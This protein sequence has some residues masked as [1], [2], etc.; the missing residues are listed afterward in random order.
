MENEAQLWEKKLKEL[1][2]NVED[3]IKYVTAWWLRVSVIIEVK[4]K[5]SESVMEHITQLM[6]YLRQVLREQLDQWFVPG[7]LFT[8]TQLAAWVVDRSG[9]LGTQTSFNIHKEPKKFIQVILACSMLLP[10]RLG[11]DITMRI[12]REP[13]NNGLSQ[14]LHS[15]SKEITIDDYA[16]NAHTQQWMIEM[17]VQD[18][19]G[20]GEMWELF[21][22]TKVLSVVRAEC[23]RGR[24][25][26]VWAARKLKDVQ[27]Q[28][29]D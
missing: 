28:A 4:P 15:F 1:E 18:T 21:L 5:N 11:W 10:E 29:L 17:P 6:S 8:G 19:I 12:W 13:S 23:M 9:A 25:I 7:L 24:T 27:A 20:N 14:Y 3:L 26:V 2:N 16:N 22:T